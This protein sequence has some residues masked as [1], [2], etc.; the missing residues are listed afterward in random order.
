MRP[1]STPLTPDQVK[2]ADGLMLSDVVTI[3]D[4]EMAILTLS[5][6]IGRIEEQLSDEANQDDVWA[7][8]AESGLRFKN[9]LKQ[10][11]LAALGDLRRAS[12]QEA[13]ETKAQVLVGQFKADWPAQFDTSVSRARESRPDLW[14]Q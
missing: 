3:A 6:D 13:S 12:R 11:L 5:R 4:H 14:R 10:Q 8:R 7:R 1:L 9:A 2:I